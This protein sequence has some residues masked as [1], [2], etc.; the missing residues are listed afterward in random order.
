MEVPDILDWVKPDELLLTTAY[1]LRDDP[2]ALDALIPRLADRGLAGIA[3]KPGR[4]LGAIPLGMIQAADRHAFPLV[5]L[6]ATA[7][8]N[9][10]IKSVLTVILDAQAVR[11][12]RSAAIDDRFTRIVLS[13]GGLRQIAE[14]LG[15]LI[16]RSVAIVDA[17]D[18]TQRRTRTMPRTRPTRPGRPIPQPI[19]VGADRYGAILVSDDDGELGPD[20]LE[21]VEY[22]ATV[23]ALRQVQTRAVAAADRRLPGGLPRGTDHRPRHGP[24]RPDGARRGVCLGPGDPSGSPAGRGRGDGRSTPSPRSAGTPEEGALRHRLAEAARTSLGPGAGSSGSAVARSAPSSRR[25]TGAA[26]TTIL[27]AASPARST[28]ARSRLPCTPRPAAS[29][30]RPRGERRDRPGAGP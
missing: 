6:P 27:D 25:G 30:P 14:A 22:A 16:G 5:E 20:R 24:K 26:A 29:S 1:P 9:E 11:L 15:E 17:Q 28:F 2:A 18:V 7:S 12:E 19:Q 8:F 13:G 10:I 4:Y 23:A 21:A 3:L